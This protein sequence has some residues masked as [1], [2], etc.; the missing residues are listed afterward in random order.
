MRIGNSFLALSL[1]VWRRDKNPLDPVLSFRAR[2][3]LASI[4]PEDCVSEHSFGMVV[5][6]LDVFFVEKHEK[7]LYFLFKA[8]YHSAGIIL[9]VPIESDQ[10]AE[11]GI[12]GI[13][14]SLARR[15]PGHSAQSLKLAPAPY[16]DVQ[17][18]VPPCFPFRIR[19][20]WLYGDESGSHPF[21][22]RTTR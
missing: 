22:S 17:A 8:A 7:R 9:L 5:R 21:G 16:S 2:R 12:K 13:P 20:R 6:E 19:D 3:S 1:W 18:A 11:P 10:S 15:S 14:L 4:S